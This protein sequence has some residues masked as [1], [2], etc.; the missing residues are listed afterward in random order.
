MMMAENVDRQQSSSS[1]PQPLLIELKNKLH[2][3]HTTYHGAKRYSFARPAGVQELDYEGLETYGD[4]ILQIAIT[5]LLRR[6]YP[7]LVPAGITSLRREVVC[8]TYIAGIAV[9]YG[10]HRRLLGS[11]IS[12]QDK[13]PQQADL[14]EAYLGGLAEERGLNEAISW[15]QQVFRPRIPLKYQELLKRHGESEGPSS[16]PKEGARN[17]DVDKT[18]VAVVEE[19]K[20]RM[21]K[22][23]TYLDS[24][25]EGPAHNKRF[26]CDLIIDNPEGRP[27]ELAMVEVSG[28]GTTKK[29]AKQAAARLAVPLLQI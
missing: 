23:T 11:P 13:P 15:C 14:F 27:G 16:T 26:R 6:E 5:D 18:P 17:G 7:R 8:N 29:L 10:L 24:E 21:K 20:V 3:T 9:E 25:E 28:Y 2:L 19:W 12:L 22:R 4:S 1:S